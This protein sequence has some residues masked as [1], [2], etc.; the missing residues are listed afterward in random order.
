MRYRMVVWDFDGT[1]ADTL[2]L[3]LATYNALAARHGFRPVADP[4]A[5]RGMGSRAFLRHHGIPLLR[6]PL[7]LREY[8]AETSGRMAEVR[9]FEGLPAVLARLREAGVV[10]GI[11]SSN[12]A[13]NIGVCLRANGVGDLFAF[14]VGYPRL[15]G[16]GRALH[17]LLRAH[18]VE[19]GQALYVGDEERDVAAAHQAGVAVAAVGWGLHAPAVLARQS[20]TYFWPAPDAVWPALAGTS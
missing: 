12:S 4:A 1:L 2:A 3:A 19:P 11:L 14:V 15:F 20:P 5:V 18:R 10:Q 16:K 8:R 7:L 13:A 6:L 9:L 17:R